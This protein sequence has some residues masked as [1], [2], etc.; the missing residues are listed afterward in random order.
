MFI[1]CCPY[2]LALSKTPTYNLECKGATDEIRCVSNV[3][4]YYCLN[5]YLDEIDVYQMF[6][7]FIVYYYLDEIRCV[8]NASLY[9]CIF[10]FTRQN[11]II[12]QMFL[13]ICC[14]DSTSGRWCCCRS[15]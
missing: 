12:Y 4:L 10:L 1:S 6:L 5:Y 14:V 9:Y 11:K 7:Y 8:S 3:S 2:I 13:C 15:F